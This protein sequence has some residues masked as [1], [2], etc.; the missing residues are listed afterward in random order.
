MGDGGKW[1]TLSLTVCAFPFFLRSSVTSILSAEV[2]F[3]VLRNNARVQACRG[4]MINQRFHVPVQTL[5]SSQMLFVP[6]TDNFSLLRGLDGEPLCE[7]APLLPWTRRR[8]RALASNNI[9]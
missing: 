5:E 3:E 2:T 4:F 7:V 1:D 6:L 9:G 8:L